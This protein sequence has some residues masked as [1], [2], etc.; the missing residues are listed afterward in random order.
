MSKS[1]RSIFIFGVYL[2]ILGG[3]LLV[4]PNALLGIFQ[5]PSTNEV[6][7]RVVGML[8][9]LLGIYYMLAARKEMTD[10]FHWTVYIRAAVILFLT[11]FVLLGYVRPVLILIGVVD[12]LGAVWTG[13]TLRA[14]KIARVKS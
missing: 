4:T 2:G 12:L 6:W 9:F 11:T 8:L 10:F 3:V 7:I 13:M 1:A 5:L 14:S